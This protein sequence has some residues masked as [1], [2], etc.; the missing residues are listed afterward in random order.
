MAY[1]CA[2]MALMT[3]PVLAQT[4][5][6]VAN[7]SNQVLTYDNAYFAAFQVHSALDM[8]NRVPGFSIR[9]GDDVRGFAG[10]A[11]NVLIDGQRPNSKT[12]SLGDILNRM[13]ASSVERIDLIIG[14]ADGIDMQG[15]SKIVNIIRR[16]NDAPT[17]SVVVN[18][19]FLGNGWVKPAARLSYS[20]VRGEETREASVMV[21]SYFDE[22][23]LNGH[24]YI[25]RT[26]AQVPE[27]MRLLGEAGGQGV[28][29]RGNWT[30]PFMAGK[31]TLNGLFRPERYLGNYR[32]ITDETAVEDLIWDERTLEGGA[33]YNRP[34]GA[35]FALKLNLL[36][37]AI[38]IGFV[39]DYT[40]PDEITR[41]DEDTLVRENIAS[42]KLTWTP[43]PTLTVEGGLERAYNSRDSHIRLKVNE[44]DITLPASKVLVEE[45][46]TEASVLA[47]WKMRKTL[48]LE[49]GLKVEWS[50]LS[51]QSERPSAKDFVYPK[52]RVQLTYAPSQALSFGFRVEREVSQLD[53]DDFVSSIDLLDS[54][55]NAGNL[56][57]E[58]YKAW[59]TAASMDYR[60]WEKGA[61]ALK[62]THSDITDAIDR[63]PVYTSDGD[64]LDA[65]GNIGDG[66]ATDINA[67]LTL[68]TE[69]FGVKG[70]L[71]KLVAGVYDSKVVDPVTGETRPLSGQS[72][73]DWEISFSQ[74]LPKRKL[75]WGFSAYNGYDETFYR[76]SEVTY[77]RGNLK[78]NLFGEYK[79]SAK[80]SVRVEFNNI[81]GREHDTDRVRYDGDRATGSIR[82]LEMTRF[83]SDPWLFIRI[84]RE[85]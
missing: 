9:E 72:E 70:G 22:G 84:R 65:R 2:F 38:D 41:F 40:N 6:E 8:V 17:L 77:A 15:Q 21:Y 55:I 64:V 73:S 85:V 63:V 29:L 11:G 81:T 28:E 14:G 13:P 74:D 47:T 67:S 76:V 62:V 78:L 27:R 25:F 45:D 26:D 69:R 61:V 66:T 80:T 79:P 56:D 58:P 48:T 49:T 33:E 39:S 54:T 57:L 59:V 50:T 7:S 35:H 18:S 32:Y 5:P 71:L 36:A 44:A 53:F 4:S 75:T 23:T 82:A 12:D 42:G 37:K 20:H 1:A 19:R 46:R 60:F 43:G 51:Q 16:T 24:K 31:L 52:P 10:A 34:L 30:R 68:P 3:A 83:S